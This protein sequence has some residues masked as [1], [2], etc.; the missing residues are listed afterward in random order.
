MSRPSH[1]LLNL[2]LENKFLD[3][4]LVVEPSKVRIALAEGPHNHVV[5]TSS[6]SQAPNIW[7]ALT[8]SLC[9]CDVIVSII[10]SQ[11]LI[12]ALELDMLA[13]PN[14]FSP[15]WRNQQQSVTVEQMPVYCTHCTV[16]CDTTLSCGLEL[17]AS[18]LRKWKPCILIFKKQ[19]TLP[20]L[21]HS[22]VK[23]TCFE[24]AAEINKETK[25]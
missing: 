12:N 21:T 4:G 7:S 19:I 15:K 3:W 8:L 20:V 5:T 22:S 10:K 13:F 14:L 23:Q 24:M 16:L 17:R 11:I 18:V 9:Y 25:H 1:P 6:S 2:F